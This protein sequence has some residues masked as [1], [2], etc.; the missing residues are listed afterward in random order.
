MRKRIL[1]AALCALPLAAQAADCPPLSVYEAAGV[2]TASVPLRE[3]MQTLL[4]GTAWKAEVG[5]GAGN[6]R[7]TLRSV[8]GPLDM[9]VQ[10]VVSQAGAASLHPVSST[11][12]TSRCVVTVDVLRP[13]P[14]PVVAQ[15]LPGEQALLPSLARE[16][17]AGTLQARPVPT[18]LAAGKML[19]QALEEYV[20]SQGWTLR[21]NIDADYVLDVD[22]PLPEGK[23]L[24]DTVTWVVKTYQA[25]GGMAGVVPRFAKANRVVVIEEMDVRGAY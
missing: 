18:K 15:P 19:S 4:A 5:E 9:V 13:Q 1:L 17:V 14:Q 8:S 2:T 6:L 3:A 24:I 22:L 11:A 7:V 25:Q 12:D 21:W 10:R 20:Y 23:G 16:A